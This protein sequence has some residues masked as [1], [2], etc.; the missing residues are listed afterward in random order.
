MEF[1]KE[2]KYRD[3]LQKSNNDQFESI[4]CILN[5]SY[6]QNCINEYINYIIWTKINRE[7]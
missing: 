5:L 4:A 1:A 7:G 2:Y 3:S 6:K